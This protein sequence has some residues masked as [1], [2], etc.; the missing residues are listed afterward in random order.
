MSEYQYYEFRAIDRPLTQREMVALREKST[1]ARITATRFV[2]DYSWGDFRGNADTWMAR[3]FDAHVYIANWGTHILMLRLPKRQL[4]L[5][6]ARRYCAGGSAKVKA[7]ASA[8]ILTF[9]SDDEDGNGW[10]EGAGELAR[11][12]AI[13]ADLAHGDR[14]LLYLGWLLKVQRGE[15]DDQDVEPPIPSGLGQLNASLRALVEFL[16]LDEDLISAAALASPKVAARGRQP[17]GRTVEQILG[18]AQTPRTKRK[19]R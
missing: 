7:T 14:R 15:C 16:R 17:R 4:D 3:Y 10:V 5:K 12:I 9:V 11:M 18:T 8:T 19:R 1:R 13:R 6:T 2:N